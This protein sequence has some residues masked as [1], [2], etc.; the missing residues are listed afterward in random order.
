MGVLPSLARADGDEEEPEREEPISVQTE[1]G[2]EIDA[3]TG[4][5][6]LI[7]V[8]AIA[9]TDKGKVRKNNEDSILAMPDQH[10]FVI[11]DGMG[12]Y[13]GGEVASK[14]AVDVMGEA[15]LSGQ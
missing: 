1:V 9:R 15:F 4:P 13:A 11:A 8:T 14:I 6:A 2:E 10:L 3:P 12:G 7:L 5:N